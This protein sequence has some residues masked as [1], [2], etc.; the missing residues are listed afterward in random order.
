MPMKTEAL[1]GAIGSD[2]TSSAERAAKTMQAPGHGTR[3]TSRTSTS[4]VHLSGGNFYDPFGVRSL[5][6]QG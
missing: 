5:L 6:F 3:E 2:T 4:F 1:D